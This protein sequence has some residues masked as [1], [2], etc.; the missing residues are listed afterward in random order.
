M[1]QLLLAPIRHPVITIAL[2]FIV[3]GFQFQ[4]QIFDLPEPASR[5]APKAQAAEL[6]KPLDAAGDKQ[7]PADNTSTPAVAAV[8]RMPQAA[9]VE[10]PSAAVVAE[11]EKIATPAAQVLTTELD[12]VKHDEKPAVQDLSAEQPSM[13]AVAEPLVADDGVEVQ[14]SAQPETDGTYQ[15]KIQMAR[16]TAR[17][18]N[19]AAALWAY[20]QVVENFP[21]QLDARGEWADLLLRFRRWPQA[22]EQYRLVLEALYSTGQGERAQRI[23]RVIGRYSPAF[24]R[25]LEAAVSP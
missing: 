11:S 5:P 9:V 12:L 19:P 16:V 17:R 20:Q 6:D 8:E 21:E 1:K 4:E 3:I 24:A 18:G 15:E 22:M 25:D 14:Q 2:L 23:V 13:S 10:E 7:M